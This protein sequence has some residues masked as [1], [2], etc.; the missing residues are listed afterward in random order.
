VKKLHEIIDLLSE[1]PIENPEI[2]SINGDSRGWAIH[3]TEKAFVK[4]FDGYEPARYPYKLTL[5]F[6][7]VEVFCLSNAGQGAA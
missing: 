5:Q 1:N 2:L 6:N 3:L 7:N 4:H